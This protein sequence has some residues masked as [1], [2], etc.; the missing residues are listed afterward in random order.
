MNRYA[1]K[2]E[3]N[4]DVVI[5]D[6]EDF[7]VEIE[8]SRRPLYKRLKCYFNNMMEWN[9]PCMSII[10]GPEDLKG[11]VYIEDCIGR[12]FMESSTGRYRTACATCWARSRRTS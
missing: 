4:E 12:P 5:W 8:G 3:N 11:I 10:A 9:K 1:F 7:Y 6:Y 2:D